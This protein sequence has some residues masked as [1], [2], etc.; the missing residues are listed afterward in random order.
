MSEAAELPGNLVPIRIPSQPF[1]TSRVIYLVGP[2]IVL[3]GSRVLCPLTKGKMV[4]NT[5]KA[6]HNISPL[7]L[8]ASQPFL[9]S[10]FGS[11]DLYV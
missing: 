3:A 4:D 1:Q 5:K 8:T 11:T 7:T 6:N 9:H 2:G 10:V